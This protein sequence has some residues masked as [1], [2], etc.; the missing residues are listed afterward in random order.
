[1]L[2]LRQVILIP[3]VLVM[4]VLLSAGPEQGRAQTPTGP[5][6]MSVQAGFDGS[7]RDNQWM[8]VIVRLSNDGDD[9]TG[10]LVIRPA[11]SGGAIVNTYS[12]PI[13]LPAGARQ[14]AFLYITARAQTS[15]I[16]V[17]LIDDSGLIVTTAPANL[18][19]IQPH[20]RLFV[21][22]SEAVTGAIDLTH[23][24]SGG[25]NAYQAIWLPADLPEQPAALD[26]VDLILI[27][28]ADTGVLTGGQRAALANWIA[29]GGHLI[30][31]GG[32]NWQ[33]TS[34]GISD[35]LPLMPEAS[36]TLEQLDGLAQWLRRDDQLIGATVIATGALGDDAH[37]LAAQAD[38][39]LIARRT[40]GLGTVD[41]MAA[42]PATAPLRGWEGMAGVWFTLATSTGA[43]PGWSQGV[44][45]WE[46]AAH[47]V[48]ILPGYDSL[49]DVLPIIGFLLIYIALM[50]PLNYV[51]LN[52]LNRREWAWVTI[53]LLIAVFSALAWTLGF[54]LRGN[55]ATL[56]RLAL[57]RAWPDA[58]QAR[59][60][61]LVGLLSPRR[62][63]YTLQAPDGGMLRPIQ[64]PSAASSLLVSNTQTSV[65]IR[66][67]ER[68]TA[69]DFTVDASFVAGFDASALVER[70]ALGGTAT[71]A[72]DG[73][74]GGQ[75]VR[76]A[77]R[78]QGDLTLNDP[79]ILA[80][81]VSLMLE[82]PLEPG[83]VVP[84]ELT[85][86]GEGP[87]PS[88][89]YIPSPP[90]RF[91]TLGRSAAS[92]SL[93]SVIDILGPNE[94][95]SNPLAAAYNR[96]P[97]EQEMRRRQA[98]LSAFIDDT[99][100]VTGRGDQVYLVGW[101]STLP[102]PVD[103]GGSAWSAQNTTAYIVQLD[104]TVEQPSGPVRI[105][106]DRFTWMTTERI[107]L[108]DMTPVGLVMQPGDSAVFHY[109]PLPDAVL[110]SVETITIRIDN[111]N[112]GGRVIPVYIYN[113]GRDD[114]EEVNVTAGSHVIRDPEPFLGPQNAV[115]LR[116][117]SDEVGGYLRAGRVTIEQ[118]GTF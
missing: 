83:A 60:D 72:Y 18:R 41:F 96:T 116:L 54:N 86:A 19:P 35:L 84:F 63:E 40:L 49:P 20:D 11:T 101:A 68:F 31:S 53:P 39:P 73:E 111:I 38:Q 47:A 46:M 108:S 102:L 48:E 21:V 71:I 33:A 5:I 100:S 85:I 80:R 77:V 75:M 95:V 112:T 58:E 104:V 2:N 24:R 106:G 23:I 43:Q 98:F 64:R 50:G 59:A 118:T 56:N 15:Q 97:E 92:D 69:Q 89:F 90:V 113:W 13:T 65:D 114:W 8:P 67:S 76:G 81:G 57:V 93:Q 42:D 16:R 25:Y 87:P 79:V 110:D 109:T 78:N 37:V 74:T 9:L 55:E 107:S 22:I 26:A 28:D 117:I 70:P 14:T 88:A 27:S 7:F 52:R 1:M 51:I 61:S 103:L 99:Y 62:T 105:A 4:L 91:T 36:T 82:A 32:P 30:V 3:A 94:Y 66:Q 115:R 17:E 45:N 44:V 10:E 12:T 6:S 29:A 34:A